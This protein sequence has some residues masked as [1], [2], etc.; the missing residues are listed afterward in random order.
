MAVLIRVDGNWNILH[1]YLRTD[2][3]NLLNVGMN[4]MSMAHIC[5]G[6]LRCCNERMFVEKKL[7]K[8]L[9]ADRKSACVSFFTR[10]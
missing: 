2:C 6:W 10:Q 8:A 3:E 5:F 1:T 9:I 4:G 7:Q